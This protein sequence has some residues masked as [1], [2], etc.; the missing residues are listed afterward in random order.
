MDQFA[1]ISLFAWR[2][3]SRVELKFDSSLCVLTGPN[4][5]GKTTIL[6][7]LGR[8]FG[9]NVNFVSTP[10]LGRRGRKFW[11]DLDAAF[12]K[13]FD[14]D[15]KAREVGRIRY[16]SGREC[17]LTAPTT[18]QA[19]Y[20]LKYQNQ[21]EVQG[22][23]IPSHRPVSSYV[24]VQNIPTNP[25]SNQQ[26]YQEFQQLLFQVYG[27]EN[28][29]NPG[30]ILKQSLIAL[31]LFGYGNAAVQPNPEYQSLYEGFQDV[32]R[33]LLPREI[34]FRH[35][36]VRMPDIVL[37]TDSGHFPLDAMSG[38]VSAV[39]SMAW[40]IFMYGVDKPNC[41]VLIDEPE[42]HL[43][44]SMQREFLP[45]LMSAFPTYQFI[46]ATHSPFIVSS[47]ADATVYAL[48]Y[49][50]IDLAPQPSPD[51]PRRKI[52]SRRL[53]NVDLAGSPN[54]ILREV[55]DVPSTLPLW[56]ETM[57]EQVLAKYSARDRTSDSAEAA[58]KELQDLGLIDAL[59][60]TAQSRNRK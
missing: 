25:K 1:G 18:D 57:V 23:N 9:W 60:S 17:V 22:L 48:V 52:H 41:T 40:Q 59:G 16:K 12:E 29:R 42:N 45:A 51:Q 39:F 33:R 28:S 31:A 54:R 8:H 50:D 44:P 26:Q 21:A 20:S 53:E 58:Y 34:G 46:V 24:A 56:V 14:I 13:N 35:L 27:S 55:L 32:L 38:G 30:V 7:V 43:H 47:A 10:W 5:C 36:E 49:E 3:F 37:V 15:P 11:S 6:N 19:Q 2:Q 4:G